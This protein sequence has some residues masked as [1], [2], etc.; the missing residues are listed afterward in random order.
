[1]ESKV[2]LTVMMTFF[3]LLIASVAGFQILDQR[4]LYLTKSMG[5]STWQTFYYLRMPAALPVLFSGLK[6]SATI[7]AT[8]A[9]VAEFVGANRGLGYLLLQA[10]SNLDTPLVFAILAIL[11][12]IGLALNYLVEL[13]EYLTTPWRRTRQQ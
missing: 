2:L 6:T 10:S 4:Y 13:A 3:P 8:A 11:T 1:M 12:L 5:A 9:I 7:A